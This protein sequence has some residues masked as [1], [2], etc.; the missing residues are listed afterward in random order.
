MVLA[1]CAITITT[2]LFRTIL[3]LAALLVLY[4]GIVICLRASGLLVTDHTIKKL[5][6]RQVVGV[7]AAMIV[8]IV[9]T[10]TVAVGLV[11][12]NTDQATSE[13][14][15]PGV[16]RLHRA[17]RATAQPDRVAGEPQR[18][19]VGRVQLP[20]RRA[21]DHDPRAAER[22]RPVLHARRVLRLRRQGARAHEPRRRREPRAAPEGARRR[23]RARA[24]P[25][26]CAH[27]RG[28]HVGQEAGRVLLPRLLRARRGAGEP[29]LPEHRRLPQ[30]QPHRRRDHRRRGLHPT[31]G[32]QA[33]ARGVGVVASRVATEP[34]AVRV[35]LAIRHGRAAR[36][37]H[38]EAAPARRHER[39]AR[40]RAA[41]AA[42][43]LRRLPGDA[44]H[45]QLDPAV[46]LQSEPRGRPTSRSSS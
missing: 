26:R 1:L 46:Q 8:A 44:V 41:L 14:Q 11:A 22:G 42:R 40:R 31:E 23:S 38:R 18:D 36:V 24:R 10:G 35:A 9:F 5:H 25:R 17:V 4:V 43:H 20:R 29:D 39:E 19:V 13:S 15:Q 7:F 34:E 21:H 27:R 37:A 3:V 16:Q 33:R 30:P 45:L 12:G 28:R 6:K 32:P 2:T